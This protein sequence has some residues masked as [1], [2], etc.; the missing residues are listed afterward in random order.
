MRIKLNGKSFN[1]PD[2]TTVCD[3]IQLHGFAPERVAAELNG[4]LVRRTDFP[5]TGLSDGDT[6][7]LV[8]F[9]GGGEWQTRKKY[10]RRLRCGTALGS[11]KFSPRRLS[12]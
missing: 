8:H 5:Q 11:R 6:V 9:V 2:G 10:I 3:L 4:A 7:E 1:C 12:A